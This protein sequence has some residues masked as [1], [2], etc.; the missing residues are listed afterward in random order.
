MHA[1]IVDGNLIARKILD[2]LKAEVRR[3]NTPPHLGVVLV[4]AS[5]ASLSYIQKKKREALNIGMRFSL[6]HFPTA[7]SMRELRE[8]IR[9]VQAKDLTGIIVQLPLPKNF[10]K[11]IILNEI[12]PDLD[13]D[14]LTWVSLG[15]LITGENVL[16]P[17]SAAA[18]LEIFKHYKI[19]LN[20]KHIV[21]VGQGELIGKPLTNILVK[22]PVTLTICGKETKDLKSHTSK[23]DIIITGVGKKNLIRGNM[24]KK[25]AIV[26]D[27]GVSFENKKM[28]GDVNF[29]EVSK[30][31]SILTPTP[32]G[33][34]PITVAKLLENTVLVAKRKAL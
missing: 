12:H 22:Q 21:L 27:A 31:A 34:G 7:V 16:V 24:V 1:E 10:D 19:N 18:V 32:G 25:G 6:Y 8:E 23:A 30:V 11:K 20:G 26:I 28:H 15:K 3:L 4:G 17:P 5:G 29:A 2:R 9:V 13:V 33:V 14:C